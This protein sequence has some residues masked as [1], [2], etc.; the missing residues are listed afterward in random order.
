[1]HVQTGCSINDS[2][3]VIPTLPSSDSQPADSPRFLMDGLSLEPN[4][5]FGSNGL[6]LEL[7]WLRYNVSR[8]M[9]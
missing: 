4:T 3:I 9:W 2:D 5:E 8:S 1:M 6:E 7:G